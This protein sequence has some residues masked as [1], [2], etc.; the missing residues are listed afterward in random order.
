MADNRRRAPEIPDWTVMGVLAEGD[1]LPE[2]SYT[3]GLHERGLPELFLWDRPSL[4][5]DPGD[6]WSFHAQERGQML[7]HWARRLIEGRLE[8]GMTWTEDMDL[9]LS[10][11]TFAAGELVGPL[12]VE[13][14]MLPSGAQVL[15]I[16]FSLRRDPLRVAA[17]V[18]E[19]AASQIRRWV[20]DVVEALTTGRGPRPSASSLPVPPYDTSLGQP[21]GPGGALVGALRTAFAAATHYEL[22][23]LLIL[24]LE[25]ER[26]GLVYAQRVLA[27]TEA[28]ARAVGLHEQHAAAYSTALDDA[29]TTTA[30]PQVRRELAEYV[31]E[32]AWTRS[33]REAVDSMNHHLGVALAA[34]YTTAVVVD[35]LPGEVAMSGLA[36]VLTALTAGS[37]R[38]LWCD[39]AA[40]ARAVQALA[41]LTPAQVSA[42]TRRFDAFGDETGALHVAALTGPGDT[43]PL[44]VLLD[45][46]PTLRVVRAMLGPRAQPQHRVLRSLEDCARAFA[47]TDVKQAA[48]LRSVFTATCLS[49]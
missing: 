22:E 6:D 4:G 26:N 43:P 42:V 15:P 34:A 35:T 36:P 46:T 49:A 13:A 24:S 39:D 17:E 21:F 30:R 9:G 44:T 3:I 48:V 11:V 7:N 8:P 33:G 23:D 16:R 40:R 32:R 25:M 2:F 19:A 14:V 38:R 1:G 10:S 27:A 31:G 5:E 12:E 20:A 37:V 47:C 29:A 18:D 45:G 41:D 28:Y